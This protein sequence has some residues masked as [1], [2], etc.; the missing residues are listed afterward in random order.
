[1]IRS[2]DA[3]SYPHL[4]VYK[5]QILHQ[6]YNLPCNRIDFISLF[7]DDMCTTDNF[8][9]QFDNIGPYTVLCPKGEERWRYCQMA[10]KKIMLDATFGCLILCT[11][12]H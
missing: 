7:Y 8:M 3:V 4:D 1:M 12:Y 10:K 9:L 11:V 2:T 5:R 6:I